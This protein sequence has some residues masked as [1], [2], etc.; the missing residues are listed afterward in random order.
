M[1]TQTIAGHAAIGQHRPS[2]ANIPPVPAVV[3]DP[4]L[5]RLAE[6]RDIRLGDLVGMDVGLGI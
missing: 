5:L 4:L 6:C 1:P 3:L 2:R